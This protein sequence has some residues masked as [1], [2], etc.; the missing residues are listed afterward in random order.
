M[1]NR[2]STG[3]RTQG[4]WFNVHSNHWAIETHGSDN[5]SHHLTCMGLKN[6]WITRIEAWF[7]TVCYIYLCMY[8]FMYVA[9]LNDNSLKHIYTLSIICASFADLV[10]FR[11][12]RS[13]Y[14][15]LYHI[16]YSYTLCILVIWTLFNP[17]QVKWWESLANP[18]ISIAQWLECWHVEPETLGSSPGWG[19]IFHHLLQ[20]CIWCVASR[21]SFISG[22]SCLIVVS[23]ESYYYMHV[24]GDS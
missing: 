19:T 15:S 8:L 2:A 13:V 23:H 21:I 6:V 1:K 7:F 18:C 4:L 12:L 16:I 24:I 3:T 14:N 17:I 20:T 5:D 11:V 10:F 22:A 9:L